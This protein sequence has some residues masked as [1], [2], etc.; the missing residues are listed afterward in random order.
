[1]WAKK[2]GNEL[3]SWREELRDGR[4]KICAFQSFEAR[5]R[6]DSLEIPFRQLPENINTVQDTHQPGWPRL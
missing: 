4:M 3:D 1:M 5:S 6:R 2:Q